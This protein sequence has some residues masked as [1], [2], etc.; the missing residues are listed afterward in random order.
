MEKSY[1]EELLEVSSLGGSCGVGGG[2]F[3]PLPPHESVVK[4]YN[5]QDPFSLCFI[6]LAE[7]DRATHLNSCGVPSHLRIMSYY[8]S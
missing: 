8:L 4:H 7:V 2:E 6:I 1:Y 3:P 5:V